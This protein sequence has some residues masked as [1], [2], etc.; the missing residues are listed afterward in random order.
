[1]IQYEM[2][3]SNILA[4]YNKLRIVTFASLSPGP[5]RISIEKC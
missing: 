2:T 5:R 3:L 1:M 4:I